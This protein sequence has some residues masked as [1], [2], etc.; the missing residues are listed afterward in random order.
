MSTFCSRRNV[1]FTL[2]SV[3]LVGSTSMLFQSGCDAILQK[4][5]TPSTLTLRQGQKLNNWP[6]ACACIATDVKGSVGAGVALEVQ[7]D[8]TVNWAVDTVTT[9]GS[10]VNIQGVLF[11]VLA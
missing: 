10:T 3:L 11:A 6:L 2:K 8:K 1:C 4:L 7:S 5:A 9:V